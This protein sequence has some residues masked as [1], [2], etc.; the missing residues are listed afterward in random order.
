MLALFFGPGKSPFL[1]IDDI[2]SLEAFRVSEYRKIMNRRNPS[3]VFE[4]LLCPVAAPEYING[5]GKCFYRY[6]VQMIPKNCK[7]RNG[8]RQNHKHIVPIETFTGAIDV[9]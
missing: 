6:D 1:H 8:N 7:K 2:C 3:S 5:T 9:F 4:R